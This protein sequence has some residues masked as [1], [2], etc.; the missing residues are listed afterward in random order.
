MKYF[1]LVLLVLFVYFLNGCNNKNIETKDGF[2]K[3]ELI[4]I[5]EE[6]EFDINYPFEIDYYVKQFIDRDKSDEVYNFKLL[7]TSDLVVGKNEV[8]LE[9]TYYDGKVETVTLKLNV[10]AEIIDYGIQHFVFDKETQTIT[11]F[12]SDEGHIVI[13][14]LI[15]GVEVLKIG[16]AS[17]Q[18]KHI[19]SIYI[20]DN[21]TEIGAMAFYNCQSLSEIIKGR[22]VKKV[23][24]F[25]FSK[26]SLDEIRID[27]YVINNYGNFAFA[28][29]HEAKIVLDDKIDME[30]ALKNWNRLGL[31]AELIPNIN[32]K[33]GI[34]YLESNKTIYG[35]ESHGWERISKTLEEINIEIINDYL[36]YGDLR[37]DQKLEKSYVFGKSIKKIGAYAFANSLLYNL[38]FGEDLVEIEPYAFMNTTIQYVF[39]PNNLLEISDNAFLNSKIETIKLDLN[40][41]RFNERWADIGFPEF[42]KPYE[43]QIIT[44]ELLLAGELE[45]FIT[46]T[47]QIGNILYGVGYTWSKFDDFE[48]NSTNEIVSYLFKYDFIQKTHEIKLLD[49]E[50][51]GNYDSIL[52]LGNDTFITLGYK[53]INEEV[54]PHYLKFNKELDILES[55][56][57]NDNTLRIIQF[58]AVN[59]LNE[60]GVIVENKETGYHEFIIYNELLVEIYRYEMP[61]QYKRL[62]GNV[63]AHG[64]DFL[65]YGFM[66]NN[67]I[68]S[69]FVFKVNSSKL[70][71]E[72]IN[73]DEKNAQTQHLEIFSDKYLLKIYVTKDFINIENYLYLSFDGTELG[74]ITTFES[75]SYKYIEDIFIIN[76]RVYIVGYNDLHAGYKFISLYDNE[77]N[78]IKKELLIDGFYAHMNI[79]EYNMETYILFTTSDKYYHD[80]QNENNYNVVLIKVD[81]S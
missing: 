38:E 12:N 29:I 16:D 27:N 7:T 20:P 15:D 72:Y 78:L 32:E 21:I 6:N 1:K 61:K 42:T 47:H 68:T 36:F 41:T 14:K 60:I 28:N 54:F 4:K 18:N 81:F 25:A 39:I 48:N 70:I 11:K 30:V 75:F 31:S 65:V 71:F 9:I 46:K 34:Y 76:D 59:D 43:R 10:V 37:L 57:I 3:E 55:G 8:E 73:S 62:Y 51:L 79:H 52:Y 74:E 23:G 35:I 49:N 19:N 26:T 24:E 53:I 40:E 17:F 33:N 50:E 58:A 13:P 5:I 45:D 67:D 66:A 80:G 56:L 44:P 64:N 2:D 63:K 22:N 77:L 69:A